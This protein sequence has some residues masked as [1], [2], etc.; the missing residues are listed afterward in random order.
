MQQRPAA[1]VGLQV[2]GQD[3]FRVAV[4]ASNQA[5]FCKAASRQAPGRT[6]HPVRHR[7]HPDKRP[8][9]DW[10]S[11]A[12]VRQYRNRRSEGLREV[13]LATEHPLPIAGKH[14]SRTAIA[15]TGELARDRIFRFAGGRW[16]AVRARDLSTGSFSRFC[17]ACRRAA[18]RHR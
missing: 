17:Q 13:A 15:L 4:A 6:R 16:N 9:D 8:S 11:V 2:P 1:R 7:L 12:R 5:A 14:F 3:F 18:F 10:K